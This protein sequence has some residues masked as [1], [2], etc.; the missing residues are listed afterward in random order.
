ML[1]G[2]SDTVTAPYSQ[3][4]EAYGLMVNAPSKVLYAAQSDNHGLPRLISSHA[5]P[6]QL[7]DD[8]AGEPGQDALD[9]RFYYAAL[10]AALEG[11]D[12]LV[13]AMGN[14]SDGEPVKKVERLL[15][16]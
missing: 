4:Q 6:V 3:Q 8:A 14:W 2:N 15:P 11:H 7:P 16:E 9:Y 5:A 13:F 10:D 12:S 1:W